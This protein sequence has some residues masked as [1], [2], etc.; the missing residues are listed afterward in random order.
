MNALTLLQLGALIDVIQGLVMTLF[1][2]SGLLLILVVLMQE[3]KGGGIA[4][5]FGGAGAET[6]GVKA[7][8]VNRFTAYLGFGFLGLALLY[9]GLESKSAGPT[10]LTKT[11]QTPAAVRDAG[12]PETPV[13]PPGETTPPGVP[14]GGMPPDPA[15]GVPPADGVP[16]GGGAPPPEPAPA[17]VPAPAP[18]PAPP[19]GPAPEQPAM[20]G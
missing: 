12:S 3:G 18:A 1:I 13:T 14:P 2:L 7:G 16:P 4:G 17:P 20:G 5:A 6:F 11:V 19:P 8:A 10:D 9:A 15:P